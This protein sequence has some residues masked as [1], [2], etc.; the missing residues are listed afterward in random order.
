M[1]WEQVRTMI[2][3]CTHKARRSS[4]PEGVFINAA[5]HDPTSPAYWYGNGPPAKHY[6]LK[7]VDCGAEDWEAFLL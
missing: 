1:Q 3:A 7:P 2:E 5:L 4:W 6:T